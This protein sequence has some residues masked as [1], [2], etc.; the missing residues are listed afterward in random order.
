MM[1]LNVIS[2]LDV[3]DY[4]LFEVSNP[5]FCFN[6]MKQKIARLSILLFLLLTSMLVLYLTSCKST[7]N[8]IPA[9][10]NAPILTKWS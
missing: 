9:P 1:V 6:K 5:F 8:S 7:G 3:A 2:T 4:L 10:K